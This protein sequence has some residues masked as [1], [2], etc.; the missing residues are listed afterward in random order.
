MRRKGGEWS[1]LLAPLI[2]CTGKQDLNGAG[3]NLLYRRRTFADWNTRQECIH[4]QIDCTGAY[5]PLL[6]LPG[7]TIV[8][9]LHPLLSHHESRFRVTQVVSTCS[10][11]WQQMW[12]ANK[13]TPTERAMKWWLGTSKHAAKAHKIITCLGEREDEKVVPQR[14]GLPTAR[15]LRRGRRTDSYIQWYWT[16]LS[17]VFELWRQTT[18]SK[19]QKISF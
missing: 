6:L 2:T 16:T 15:A 18:D 11:T 3:Q 13:L 17:P 19:R 8:K 9:K 12:W 5:K 10:C 1:P 14:E 4:T 7:P